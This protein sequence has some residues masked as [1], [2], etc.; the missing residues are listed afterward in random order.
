MN[1]EWFKK[2]SKLIKDTK[3]TSIYGPYPKDNPEGI[4][5][6]S[7]PDEPERKTIWVNSFEEL[8]EVLA[9]EIG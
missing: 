3:S 7:F 4:Y 2:D 5:M 9:T 8:I 1:N 6:I